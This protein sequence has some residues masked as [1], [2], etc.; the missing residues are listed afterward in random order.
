MEG[1]FGGVP[2]TKPN[3]KLENSGLSYSLEKLVICFFLGDTFLSE[4]IKDEVDEGFGD[5]VRDGEEADFELP[6]SI[7]CGDF[8]C[9]YNINA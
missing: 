4:V 2:T 5:L 9:Y 7:C 6:I 1:R 3:T 8:F